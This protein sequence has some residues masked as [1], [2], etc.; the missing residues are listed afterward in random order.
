[1]RISPT[2]RSLWGEA[3]V[4]ERQVLDEKYVIIRPLGSGPTGA[5]YAGENLLLGNRVA[6]KVIDP[7]LARRP[8]VAERVLRKAREAASLDHPN[9][10][11]LLDLGE[12]EGTPYIVTEPLGGHSLQRE[13]DSAACSVMVACDLI[14]QLLS[15]LDYAHA[16][17]VV[18]GALHPHNLL[19]SYPRPGVPWVKV[20][21]FGLF[22]A[23]EDVH[24]DGPNPAPAGGFRAP[25][26]AS[27]GEIDQRA[28][29][30][31]AAALLHA[32]LHGVSP[33]TEAETS[34]RVP[35]DLTRVLA[36]ALR[37]NPR[38]RIGS[39]QALANRL[40][41]FAQE[42]SRPVELRL[43]SPP[44]LRWINNAP[45]AGA[46]ISLASSVVR[47]VAVFEANESEVDERARAPEHQTHDPVPV[48]D[49]GVTE[50][51]LR[52]PRFPSDH[53]GSAW[54]KRWRALRTNLASHPNVG[55]AWLF[56][57]ASVGAGI[58]CALL[59]AWMQ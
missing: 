26:Y 12:F 45:A 37:P 39:A 9:I 7:A 25:E 11:S 41:P 29:V 23:L 35:A 20:T 49:V 53:R 38:D 40:A 3:P 22:Q 5:L 46:A 32:L 34:S 31:S 10:A 56:A 6:I 30:Y 17:G 28:D 27:S 13:I 4:K 33:G 48:R 50:S 52:N 54:N 21:D 14:L 36:E 18:H 47:S 51:L 59:A 42:S 15:A 43:S 44:S 8:G 16:S 24:G 1:L 58:A 57:L 19:I 2:F 55:A